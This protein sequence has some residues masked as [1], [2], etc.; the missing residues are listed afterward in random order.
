MRWCRIYLGGRCTDCKQPMEAH[1][2]DG[3]D[4]P[5]CNEGGVS[6]QVGPATATTVAR[7]PGRT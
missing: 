5:T 3:L 7:G 2:R 4:C 6:L 1:G